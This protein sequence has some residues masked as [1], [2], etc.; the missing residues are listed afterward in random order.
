M[1]DGYGLTVELVDSPAVV[2]RDVP[3]MTA[4]DRACELHGPV[5]VVTVSGEGA[6]YLDRSEFMKDDVEEGRVGA[7][8]TSS[9]RGGPCHRWPGSTHDGA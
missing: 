1:I 5:G 2:V 7:H 9:P 4:D 8:I 3:T 6:I